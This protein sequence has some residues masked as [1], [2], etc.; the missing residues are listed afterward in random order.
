VGRP[1][2]ERLTRKEAAKAAAAAAVADPEAGGPVGEGPAAAVAGAVAAA[3][4]PE[5]VR[6]VTV[7]HCMLWTATECGVQQQQ[8][9]GSVIAMLCHNRECSSVMSAVAAAAG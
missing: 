8:H 7:K 1:K 2:P 4:E 5:Q 3:D 9:V 6:A